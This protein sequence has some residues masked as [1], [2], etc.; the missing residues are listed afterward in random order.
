MEF[1]HLTKHDKIQVIN[2]LILKE[3]MRKDLTND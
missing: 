1:K 3:N 2:L